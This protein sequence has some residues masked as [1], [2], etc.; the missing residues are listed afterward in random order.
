MRLGDDKII[1]IDVRVI[2]S[3]NRDLVDY[4][5]QGHFREDLFFRL[6]IL[7]LHLPPLRQRTEDISILINKF[8]REYNSE[9]IPLN[10]SEKT[11]DVLMRYRWP[12]N[13]RELRNLTER[14]S[15]LN[16]YDFVESELIEELMETNKKL[17]STD[18]II[19]ILTKEKI[20]E[21]LATVGNNKSK[22]AK[23]L[24]I[25]RSTL[26]RRLK[27]KHTT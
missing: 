20:E 19:P 27:D 5:K 7:V 18:V 1:P 10:L 8:S 26:W 14:I 6:N 21:V 9:N 2:V 25:D 12:G 4:V 24:G 15:V 11:L 23:I 3:T 16:T 13:I 22:A 17:F